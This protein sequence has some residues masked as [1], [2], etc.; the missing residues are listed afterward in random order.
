MNVSEDAED[1]R[2]LHVADAISRGE[3]VDWDAVR[4]EPL[5]DETTTTLVEL[6]ALETLSRFNS[7]SSMW[8]PF[9]IEHEIG[10]GAFGTVYQAVDRN[11]QLT[12]ALKVIRPFAP[13]VV[14]DANRAF[15]EARLLAQINHPNVVRVFRAERVGAEVGVSMELIKGVTLSQLIREQGRLDP[16]EAM[17]IGRDLCRALGAVHDAGMVHGDLKARNVMR[18]DGGRTV[19]MDFG[20]C[21]LAPTNG[22]RMA[23]RISGTPLYLAPEIFA[24][25]APTV[26]S[27]IYSL[28]VLLFHLVTGAYPVN[29]KSYEEIERQQ[30][31]AT[32]RRNLRDLRPD[33]P[34]SFTSIVD[35]AIADRPEARFPSA[36]AFEEAIEGY[37]ASSAQSQYASGSWKRWAAAAAVLAA[38]GVPS[39][40]M[41]QRASTT[42]EPGSTTVRPAVTAS[43]GTAPPA[44]ERSYNVDVSLRRLENGVETPLSQGA[45]VQT[46]DELSLQLRVS[47]P[48]YVYVVNEDEQGQSYLLF[49]LPGQSI[50]NPVP[51]GVTHQLPGIIN[52]T[53]VHWQVSSAGG[54]EHFIVFIS[55]EPPPSSFERLFA[56]LPHPTAGARVTGHKLSA[57]GLGILRGVG[58]LTA[59]PVQADQ[60]L[61]NSPEFATPLSTTEEVA[62]GLWVRQITLENPDSR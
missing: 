52:G 18:E 32:G 21:R 40:A 26:A 23:D 24:G 19:L 30:N 58:G 16:R 5:D 7:P 33:L 28:G 11:L 4:Q 15:R 25:S 20:A 22:P 48:A 36:A 61:R 50:P 54:R 57:A 60:G 45:R 27:D 39:L 17:T 41:W 9:D 42:T 55:P 59:T 12:V 1:P 29:G 38:I 56:T 49:P 37:L 6:Q 34:R 14:I 51:A 10:R 13:A 47:I 8:G 2:L 35:R 3:P 43:P 44:A 53:Q 31:G 62:S 46:G